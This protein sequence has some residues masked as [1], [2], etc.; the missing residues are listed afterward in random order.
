MKTLIV[1]IIPENVTS[2]EII[3]YFNS[4]DSEIEEKF[5]KFDY[6][7][8]GQVD[9]SKLS[10]KSNNDIFQVTTY[11]GIVK[12]IDEQTIEVLKNLR[13]DGTIILDE[14]VFEN[15]KANFGKLGFLDYL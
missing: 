3:K 12:L 8:L 1:K 4:Y 6:F 15:V 9:Y 7:I 13:N 5:K 10:H 11:F 2:Q 14:N